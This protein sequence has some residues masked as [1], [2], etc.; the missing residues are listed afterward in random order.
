MNSEDRV[1]DRR[2]VVTAVGVA[3]AAA[4]VLAACGT[5]DDKATKSSATSTAPA[6]G[7]AIGKT[8]DVPVG[9]S[10]IFGDVVVTQ[11]EVGTFK[12]FSTVCTHLGCRVSVERPGA[13]DCKCHGSAFGLD[14]GVLKG[15]AARPLN[16]VTINV[17]GGA[18]VRS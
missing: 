4:A 15:P 11:P 14:G 8:A 9:S 7:G 16:P 5:S 2:T 18:V 10:A 1:V 13:L 6:V 3:T 17:A 12:G